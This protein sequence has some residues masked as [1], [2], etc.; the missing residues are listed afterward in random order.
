MKPPTLLSACLARPGALD[1]A[2]GCVLATALS[3]VTLRQVYL[4][5]L[6]L[7]RDN[8]PFCHS[9]GEEE[10]LESGEMAQTHLACQGIRQERPWAAS[11]PSS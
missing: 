1:W 2:A 5:P 7:L 9:A 10:P 8:L 4:H 3:G 11:H 6:S